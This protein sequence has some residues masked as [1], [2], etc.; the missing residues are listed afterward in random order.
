[1]EEREW[2]YLNLRLRPEIRSK[3]K[4]TAKDNGTSIQAL[5]SAF[6]ESYIESPDVFR[7]ILKVSERTEQK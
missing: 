2:S 7:I 1:M 4:E 3:L 5:F 6:C